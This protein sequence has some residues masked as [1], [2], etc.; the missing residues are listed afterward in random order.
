VRLEKRA[1]LASAAALALCAAGLGF[2][3]GGFFIAALPLAAWAL[4][5]A[6]LPPPLPLLEAERQGGSAFV[7][8]G[9]EVSINI[10]ITNRGKRLERLVLEDGLPAGCALVEGSPSWRGSLDAGASVPIAY[11]V[12]VGRGA[13]RFEAVTARA[14]ELFTGAAAPVLLPCPALVV[15]SPRPLFPPDPR[16]AAAAHRPF[17]GRSRARKTGAGTDFAGTREYTPGDPLRSLNWRAE[18]LWGQGIVNVFEEERALDVGL[19]LDARAAAYPDLA[20]F[21]AAVAAAAS[22]GDALLA[23]GNR[24]ALLS[25]GST[26][27][28]TEGGLG[29]EQRLRLRRATAQAS[30]G[31]HSAFERFDN[32]PVSLFPPRSAILLVSPLLHDDLRPLRSLAALG[33]A[34]TVL[35]PDPLSGAQG[36]GSAGAAAGRSGELALRLLR[37]E[38]EVLEARLAK[39]GIAVIDWDRASPLAGRL[40]MAGRRP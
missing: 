15:A 12:R 33:Y 11:R 25:Y 2:A 18:A 20:L 21:E 38:T 37:L 16:L 28:W 8:A 14:E 23:G 3:E 34:L 27:E 29:R 22:L 5:A 10:I 9:E 31:D 19:I 17:A 7:H 30:L 36:E 6:A 40:A 4:L 35:R 24:V 32:L 1:A 39:A 26:V 13:H